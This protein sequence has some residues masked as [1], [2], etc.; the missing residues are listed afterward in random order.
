MSASPWRGSA[1]TVSRS[2]LQKTFFSYQ[3]R[4]RFLGGGT[5]KFTKPPAPTRLSQGE[6]AQTDAER[7]E[8][9]H[10]VRIS[11]TNHSWRH[12]Q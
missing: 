7:L 4:G 6:Y 3:M 1:E 5:R 9:L 11:N 10:R 12:V 8:S 2:A